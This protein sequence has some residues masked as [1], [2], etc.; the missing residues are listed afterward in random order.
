MNSS[1]VSIRPI[2]RGDWA[3][4]DRI[5]RTAFSAEAVEDIETIRR[6]GELSPE[7][8]F[9]AVTNE[10]VGYLIAHPWVA[11][12]LPPL[13]TML[14]EIPQGAATFFIHD[15]ALHPAARGQGVAQALLSA[16]FAKARE[17]GLVDAS[18]LSIQGSSVF[19]RKA[20]FVERPDLADTVGPVLNQFLK[21]EFVFMTRPDLNY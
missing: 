7:T 6:L 8:C 12:E 19:W 10:P 14:A 18:L 4:V 15:L 9:L 13:N 17:L 11:D 2:E 20:G 21:T 1:H 16:A 3:E 5:Q